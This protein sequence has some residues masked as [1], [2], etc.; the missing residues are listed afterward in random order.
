MHG[1]GTSTRQQPA[2]KANLNTRALVK[3]NF[4]PFVNLV[5]RV[6]AGGGKDAVIECITRILLSFDGVL[7]SFNG[8]TA[9]LPRRVSIGRSPT[10]RLFVM[11]IYS[12]ALSS[13]ARHA[14]LP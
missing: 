4:F 1:L 10:R 7:L 14:S 13:R 5:V 2:A 11:L 6:L 12:A 9:A 3:R 8:G